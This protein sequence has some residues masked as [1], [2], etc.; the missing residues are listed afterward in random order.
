M[1][2]NLTTPAFPCT[3]IQDNFQR[4]IVPN[5]GINKLEYF[6]LELYKVYK[7]SNFEIEMAEFLQADYNEKNNIPRDF[8]LFIMDQAINDSI[9]LIELIEQKTK[10]PDNEKTTKLVTL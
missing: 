7:T 4:L 3:P 10:T 1:N 9:A 6:A 8:N 2:V 5:A